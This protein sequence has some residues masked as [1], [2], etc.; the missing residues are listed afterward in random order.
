[1]SNNMSTR[2]NELYGCTRLANRVQF[3]LAMSMI[4]YDAVEY[5][6]SD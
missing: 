4:D 2:L 6:V 5:P 3:E 1:M